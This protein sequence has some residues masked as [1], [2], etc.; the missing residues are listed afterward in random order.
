MTPVSMTLVSRGKDWVGFG[1]WTFEDFEASGAD[2]RRE[3]LHSFI[4]KLTLHT[5]YFWI[6][7]QGGFF[8][9]SSMYIYVE[10]EKMSKNFDFQSAKTGS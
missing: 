2:F 6:I 3:L 7:H 9:A 8:V 10:C 4:I 5:F 1:F